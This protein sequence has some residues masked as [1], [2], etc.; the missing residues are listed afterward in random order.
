MRA[1]CNNF[2]PSYTGNL[3][4]INPLRRKAK[5]LLLCAVQKSKEGKKMKT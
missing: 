2:E 1:Y 5:A 3:F 4:S